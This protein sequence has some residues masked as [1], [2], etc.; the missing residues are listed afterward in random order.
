VFL[1]ATRQ[2]PR[3]PSPPGFDGSA[4]SFPGADKVEE[5]KEAGQGAVDTFRSSIP[6]RGRR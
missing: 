2:V 1:Q 6:K 5:A 3:P 4:D